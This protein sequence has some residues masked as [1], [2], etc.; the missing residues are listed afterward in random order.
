MSNATVPY[1]EVAAETFPK[2][3]HRAI[4]ARLD[5]DVVKPYLSGKPLRRPTRRTARLS[6]AEE[7]RVDLEAS[8]RGKAEPGTISLDDLAKDLG[9]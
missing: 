4:T 7:D 9:L 1:E 8:E 2:V 3:E 5:F 6:R